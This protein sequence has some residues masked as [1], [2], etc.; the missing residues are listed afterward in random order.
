MHRTFSKLISPTSRAHSSQHGFRCGGREDAQDV[1]SLLALLSAG[2]LPAS[3]YLFPEGDVLACVW[4]GKGAWGAVPARVQ[5]YLSFRNC[6]ICPKIMFIWCRYCL[7][8]FFPCFPSAEI[9]KYSLYAAKSQASRQ[10]GTN[11][12]Q[13]M[14]LCN[15][16]IGGKCGFLPGASASYPATSQ[17]P[18]LS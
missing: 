4:R 18:P 3:V 12:R 14:L 7:G 6:R 10:Y 13:N 5:W 9:W 15:G 8:K 17:R 2:M 1:T 11:Q 16:T